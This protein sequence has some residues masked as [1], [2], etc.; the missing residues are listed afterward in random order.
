MAAFVEPPFFP[1]DSHM[2]VNQIT[3][4]LALILLD[5]TREEAISLIC[6]GYSLENILHIWATWAPYLR[7][8]PSPPLG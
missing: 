5:P 1:D 4:L 7:P 3:T 8:P 2:K 6:K